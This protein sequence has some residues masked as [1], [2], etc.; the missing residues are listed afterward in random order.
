MVRLLLASHGV[1]DSV[2]N[3]TEYQPID[4]IQ[5]NESGGKND[6]G[7]TV[8]TDRPFASLFHDLFGVLF[9]AVTAT[10]VARGLPTVGPSTRLSLGGTGRAVGVIGT[11]VVLE[12]SNASRPVMRQGGDVGRIIFVVPYGHVVAA[13]AVFA[14]AVFGAMV[15]LYTRVGH[16][17]RV[18]RHG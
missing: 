8:N 5:Q 11:R 13:E 7:Y 9:L 14:S 17:G 3:L 10:V 18:H 6:T 15:S 2:Q 1:L 12:I 16:R 4:D